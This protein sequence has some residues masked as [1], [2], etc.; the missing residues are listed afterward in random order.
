MPL[1]VLISGHGSNLQAILNAQQRDQ[2]PAVTRVVVSNDPKAYGLVRAQ[3]HRIP[4][5]VI[6]HGDFTDREQFDAALLD[7]LARYTPELVVLA[8]FLRILT[9]TFVRTYR[10]QLLN[11]HPSLLPTLPG[12]RTHER[13]LHAGLREHGASVHFVTEALDSGPVILQ[14]RVPILPG[15]TAERL[16]RR[17]QTEE[18][19]IYP[20]VID[21]YAR[22]RLKLQR[23]Q[24]WL[25]GAPLSQPLRW[26]A[27]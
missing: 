4:I 3:R 16:A 8:G 7:V 1:A 26:A 17:V 21:W 10:G 2:L 12:L 27:H 6:P 19:R 18:H 23:D 20:T 24:A 14:A 25:D 15:D 5:E 13:A 22:G 9:P 11:I